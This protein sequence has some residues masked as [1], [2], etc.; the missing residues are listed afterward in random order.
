MA[1]D[2]IHIC[3]EMLFEGSNL[4]S[5]ARCL[6]T[7]YCVHL[8]RRTVRRNSVV[9]ALGFDAVDDVIAGSRDEV[10]V[11]KNVDFVLVESSVVQS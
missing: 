7:D 1:R 2:D 4:R 3:W 8:R 5:L 11:G 6:A 9:D 10:A